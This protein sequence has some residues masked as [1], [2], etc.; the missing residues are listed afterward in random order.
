LERPF[1]L[2][3]EL[4]EEERMIRDAAKS[5]AAD[6]LQPRVIEAWSQEQT[7]PKSS[8]KWVNSACLARRFPK[9]MAALALPMF[10]MA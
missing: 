2:D 6:R 4:T 3:S 1:F 7:D 8:A 9:S 5:Y 10:P